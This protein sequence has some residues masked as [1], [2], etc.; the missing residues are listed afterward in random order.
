M[1]NQWDIWFFIRLTSLDNL[2]P[3]S[4]Q[5]NRLMWAEKTKLTFTEVKTINSPT[6]VFEIGYGGN[7]NSTSRVRIFRMCKQMAYGESAIGLNGKYL[8]Q[9][10]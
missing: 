7:S 3:K 5:N 4:G 8:K 9:I 6:V 2:Q 10:S 1:M